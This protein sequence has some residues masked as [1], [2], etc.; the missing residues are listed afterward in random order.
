MGRY[1]RSCS[2]LLHHPWFPFLRGTLHFQILSYNDRPRRSRPL[3]WTERY[4][5]LPKAVFWV[6]NTLGSGHFVRMKYFTISSKPSS[7]WSNWLPALSPSVLT[8]SHFFHNNMSRVLA[9]SSLHSSTGIRS[10][11]NT[12]IAFVAHSM[13]S[14]TVLPEN[15][16]NLSFFFSLWL[17]AQVRILSISFSLSFF[18]S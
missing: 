11:P 10:I 12:F 3:G 4:L 5:T 6:H 17:P 14:L 13:S 8:W 16:Y 2:F 9:N 15:T 1:Q 7:S 18:S